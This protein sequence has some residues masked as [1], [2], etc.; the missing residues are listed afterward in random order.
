[1]GKGDIMNVSMCGMAYLADTFHILFEC[2]Q[3]INNCMDIV[4]L[5]VEKIR[6]KIKTFYECYHAGETDIGRLYII[7]TC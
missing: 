3:R 4:F 7:Y 1:M 5:F 2:V 6:I